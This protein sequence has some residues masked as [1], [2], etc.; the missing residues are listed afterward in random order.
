MRSKR[1][2]TT[3]H[4][5]LLGDHSAT[6]EAGPGVSGEASGQGWQR[7]RVFLRLDGGTKAYTSAPSCAQADRD[8][9]FLKNYF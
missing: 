4:E 8:T 5:A 3:E 9:L 2:D 7:A 6:N 1:V